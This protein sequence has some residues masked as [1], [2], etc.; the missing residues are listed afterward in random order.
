MTTGPDLKEFPSMIVLE[1]RFQFSLRKLLGLVTALAVASGVAVSWPPIGLLIATLSSAAFCATL[2]AGATATVILH[3][4]VF[5]LLIISSELLAYT[6]GT[7]ILSDPHYSVAPIAHWLD[8]FTVVAVGGLLKYFGNYRNRDFVGAIFLCQ[9]V[10]LLVVV[11]QN[12][13]PR[14]FWWNYAAALMFSF[15]AVMVPAV[16]AMACP[17][18]SQRPPNPPEYA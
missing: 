14:F 15:Q 18:R 3:S 7:T 10:I 6:L 16:L 5:C 12:S 13:E 11:I 17:S 9:A 1:N 4:I 2:R 8:F